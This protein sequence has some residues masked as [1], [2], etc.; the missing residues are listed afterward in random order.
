MDINAIMDQYKSV[1]EHIDELN[2]KNQNDKD[3]KL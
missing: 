2:Q 1:N 3:T